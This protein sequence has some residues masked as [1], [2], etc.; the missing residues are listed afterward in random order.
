MTGPCSPNDYDGQG[1]GNFRRAV[2]TALQARQLAVGMRDVSLPVV[3]TAALLHAAGKADDYRR[4]V[5][6]E[7]GRWIGYQTTLLEWLAVARGR[8][9]VPETQYLKLI[10][11]L[12][13]ARGDGVTR[14]SMEA[15]ILSVVQ[16]SSEP[17]LGWS[18]QINPQDI[19]GLEQQPGYLSGRCLKGGACRDI[20]ALAQC[21]AIVVDH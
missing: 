9:I 17:L 2:E 20:D 11:A 8:V 15:M 19:G 16:R 7:R 12:I 1:S 13:A 3:I 5:I 14:K 10:H 6:S 18:A 4:V 21:L